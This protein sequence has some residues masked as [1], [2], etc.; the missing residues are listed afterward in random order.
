MSQWN[1]QVKHSRGLGS[2][3]IGTRPEPYERL[4]MGDPRNHADS[5]EVEPADRPSTVS[6]MEFLRRCMVGG[7]V[8]GALST[9]SRDAFAAQQPLS[10]REK[11]EQ[12]FVISFPGTSPQQQ[13][14]S[15]LNRHAFGGV[16]LYGRNCESPQQIRLLLA[17][18]QGAARSPLLVCLEQEGG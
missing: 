4:S 17:G 5:S 18:L 2:R 8:A 1:L 11:V 14:V 9:V 15:L 10:I 6:R 13:T 3:R 7:A 16:I 12:L